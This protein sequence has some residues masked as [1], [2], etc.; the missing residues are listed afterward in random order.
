MQ[1]TAALLLATGMLA[2]AA[3]AA[4]AAP[5]D[6][7]LKVQS[8]YVRQFKPSFNSLYA[9]P[10]SLSG[11]SEASYSFTATAALGLRLGP[12]TEAYFDPEVAQGVPLSG[13]Q[14]LSGFTNGEMARTS[15]RNPTF[16]RARLFVR[17]VTP[18]SDDSEAVEP[19]MNQL[20][21]TQATRRLTWTL[22]NLSV[23]DLFD[24]NRYSHD[25]RSQFM[26]WTLMTHGAYD[27]A[28]DARGY[29]WGAAVEYT[30]ADWSLRAGRFLQPR[31]PNQQK[32]D[33][34]PL[35]HYGDQI[36]FEQRYSLGAD[37]PGAWRVLAF[38]N[39]ALMSRYA[40]ALQLA[41]ATASVPDLAA[42]R[43]TEHSK[44][45]LGLNVEQQLSPTLGL[46]ARA[47]WADGKTETYAFTEVDRSA[48]AGTVL[49]GSTWGRAQ[50][51]LGLALAWNTISPAHRA[52]LAAGGQTFFLGDG[53]LRYQ[54]ER[55]IEA[56]YL[57]TPRPGIGITL[58]WQRINAP[59]YNAD[60]GPVN[61]WALRLHVER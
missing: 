29:S 33:R 14:G 55:L 49:T 57:W 15:G 39:R 32:L 2:G 3:H 52:I 38:H 17:H 51:T 16:Y 13:L 20:G 36:E 26:N 1:I 47:M 12:R 50:D 58:D 7:N 11:S 54:P 28:A 34:N 4:D 48:S 24:A 22:G 21:G 53:A 30:G 42:V 45:G 40:D 35:R 46:F 43:T 44:V 8:T 18:L 25:P 5:E 19:A 10:H 59:G 61:A 37:Q 27:Y 6:W 56:Y 41:S 23:L 9:G 31:E 60:R